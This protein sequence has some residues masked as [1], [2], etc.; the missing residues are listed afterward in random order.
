[1]KYIFT[2]L[3][4]IFI[5]LNKTLACPNLA[6]KAEDI[7]KVPADVLEGNGLVKKVY[8]KNEFNIMQ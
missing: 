3:F 7:L 2:S 4:F 6:A 8:A 1:M 5:C